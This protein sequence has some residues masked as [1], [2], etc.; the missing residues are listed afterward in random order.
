MIPWFLRCEKLLLVLSCF[1]GVLA[2][3]QAQ[4]PSAVSPHVQA[5]YEQAIAARQSGDVALAIT[6]YEAILK[7]APRLASAYNNLGALYF[8]AGDYPSAVR[9]LERGLAIDPNMTSA[10][11]VLGMSYLKLRRNEDAKIRLKAALAARPTDNT[12][13]MNLAQSLLNLGEYDQAADQLRI[14]VGRNPKDQAALYLLGKTYLQLSEAALGKIRTIDPDSVTAHEVTGEIDESM[15]N[16][17]GALAEYNKAVQLGPNLP[18]TH[19]RLGNAMWMEGKWES[20]LGEFQ[21]DLHNDPRNCMTEWKMGN[22][23][24]AANHPATEA[25]PFLAD[26]VEQ[27][28]SLTQ[29]RVDRASALL[30]L[31]RPQ[32]ASQDLLVAARESPMEPS[33]HFLLA[34]AY[35]SLNKPD[36]ARVEIETYGRLQ[37]EASEATAARAGDV[38]QIKNTA[39]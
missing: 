22:T 23:L 33:I 24:L 25:L 16:Y 6:R 7:A 36:Q 26:A 32:S 11:A 1:F 27:C 9:T 34:Q 13:Q 2:P 30:K 37:R 15:H 8:D 17:D 39:R 5:L 4:E 28:P 14:Y 31:D 29:A 21:A 35:K 19:Y 3:S 18:G 12:L 20:A 38:I 10:S